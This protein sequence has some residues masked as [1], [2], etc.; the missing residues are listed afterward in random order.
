M[1][2]PRLKRAV[3]MVKGNPKGFA[4]LRNI[5]QSRGTAKGTSAG[6]DFTDAIKRRL[7]KGNSQGNKSFSSSTSTKTPAG[8]FYQT[9]G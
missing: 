3:P 2:D 4:G 9:K 6:P 8:N 7:K 5:L 1:P